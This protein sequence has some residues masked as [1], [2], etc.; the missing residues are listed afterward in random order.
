[1]LARLHDHLTRLLAPDHPAH[2]RGV[3]GLPAG[4]PEGRVERPPG[5]VPRARSA[6]G[7]R[8]NDAAGTSCSRSASRCSWRSR[9]CGRTS[10]IGSAQEARVRITTDRPERLAA[11]SRAA[12]DALHRLGGRDRRRPGCRGRVR[13]AERSP[14]AKCER[15]WNYR[16]TV[17][18]S[19][20]H[21]TLCERCVRVVTTLQS[22]QR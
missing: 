19:A 2:R 8:A 7:R 1:M 15:C 3:V 5:R 20:E 4:A 18:Q 6:V 12:G 9:A 14:H 21:P 10:Q 13:P 22:A 11:R 16:P 17:G